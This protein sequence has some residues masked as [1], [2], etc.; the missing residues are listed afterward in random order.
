MNSNKTMELDSN[1]SAC[2]RNR[3]DHKMINNKENDANVVCPKPQISLLGGTTFAMGC[4]I[5]S[6]IFISP[7][8][9]LESAGSVG[10]SLVIWVLGGVFSAAMGLAYGELGSLVPLSGG[11]YAYINKALGSAPAFLSAWI[12]TLVCYTGS[13][14]ILSLV[15]SDYLLTP[16]YGNCPASDTLRK[17]VA[18]IMIITL[19]ITN[20]ISVRFAAYTQISLTF[21]KVIALTIVSVGGIVYIAKGE[22]ENIRTGFVGTTTKVPDYTDALYKCMFAY[23]GFNRVNE[24]AEEIVNAKKNVP[25]AVLFSIIFVTFIYTTTNMSYCTLLAKDD[26]VSSSAVA[27]DWATKAIKPAAII[28]PISVMCSTYGALN[29]VGFSNGRI[30]FAAARNG[31]YPEVMSSLH[32]NTC[33]PV[34]SVIVT[35]A[36]GVL[37]L[38]PGDIGPLI[39]FTSFCQFWVI[40]LTM[41]SLC[42]MRFTLYRQK[43]TAHAFRT[44][45]PI[46]I[47]NLLIVVFMI[48]S[49]FVSSPKVEFLYGLGFVALGGI[50]YIPFVYMGRQIPGFDKVTTSLQLLLQIAPTAKI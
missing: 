46:L 29:G 24:I 49:P 11:D 36:I 15:F 41:I 19:A 20:V 40:G 10:M 31:H 48:V 9:A 16:I 25:R 3:D 39:N 12:L 50:V 17:L 18:C 42:R 37:L 4:M 22:T 1:N 34:M 47:F 5:G 13:F 38:I 8:G 35:H 45:I 44:P 26:I 6:G 23:G 43:E 14:P 28:I 27:Y 33:I 7:T 30:M 21:A 32:V 2:V